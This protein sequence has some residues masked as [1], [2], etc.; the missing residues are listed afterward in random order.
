V[1]GAA[2]CNTPIL[3]LRASGDGRALYRA[4]ARVLVRREVIAVNGNITDDDCA[5]ARPTR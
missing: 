1:K 3:E 2:N 5:S 4:L